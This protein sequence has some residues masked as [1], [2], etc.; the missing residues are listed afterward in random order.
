MLEDLR[1]KLKGWRT[2]IVAFLVGAVDILQVTDV[3]PI[4]PP[5]WVPTWMAAQPFVFLG[6]RLITHGPVGSKATG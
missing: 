1:M 3:A 5:S 4:L 6:L 2:I